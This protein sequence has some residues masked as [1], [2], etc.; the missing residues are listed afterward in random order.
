VGVALI[1]LALLVRRHERKRLVELA[2]VIVALAPIVGLAVAGSPD[3]TADRLIAGSFDRLATLGSRETLGEDSLK[4]R[5]AENQYVPP[6]VSSHPFLGIGLGTR[7]RPYDPYVDS[8]IRV[9]YDTRTYIHNAHFWILMKT[10]L[11]GYSALVWLSVA[12]LTRGFKHWQRVSDPQMRGWALGFTLA[13]L[14]VPF[15][16]IV[17]PIYMQWEWTP[18]IGVIMG[19]NE[20]ILRKATR[21][22]SAVV[23]PHQ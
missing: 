20:I 6:I 12:F 9:N 7:Y 2:L 8:I 13:Y 19:I 3:S 18:V 1:I 10:G 17:N 23:L 15:G 21:E 22:E 11:L 5:Y 14:G 4:W 16:A